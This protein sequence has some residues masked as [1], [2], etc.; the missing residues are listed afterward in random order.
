VKKLL[1]GLVAAIIVLAAALVGG[2]W[3]AEQEALRALKDRGVTWS[4]YQRQGTVRRFT[5]ASWQG[6][7]AGA[8]EVDLRDPYVLRAADI[9]ADLS[10]LKDRLS[11][12]G[13]PGEGGGAADPISQALRRVRVDISGL[14]LRWGERVIGEDLAGRYVAGQ[15]SLEGEG[16]ALQAPGPAGER[17]WISLARSLDLGPVSGPIDVEIALGEELA[18]S[19]TSP[20]LRLEHELLATSAFSVEDWALSLAGQP[21]SLSGTLDVD[22]AHLELSIACD[23]LPPTRCEVSAE[24]PDAPAKQVLNPFAPVVPELRRGTLRG[25]LGGS[26]TYVWPD[27]DWTATPRVIGLAAEG[28]APAV[29]ALKGGRFTYLAADADGERATRVTGEGTADWTPLPRIAEALGQAVMAAE[30]ITFRTHPG[31]SLVAITDALVEAAEAGELGRGGS[32]LTQQLVKNLF[33]D[34]SER[35]IARKLRELLIAVELDREL[36]KRRVLELYFNVVEWGPEIHGIKAASDYYFLKRPANLNPAECAFLAVLL[37]SPR[38]YHDLWYMR[39]RASEV[40]VGWV[41]NNMADAG[42]LSP[43]EAAKWSSSTIRFVPPPVK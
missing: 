42:W 22:G 38:T 25:E 35:T 13:A 29:E 19:L 14:D 11:S 8:V 20:A 33:L 6:V 43:Q 21:G 26:A 28:A 39:G 3:Y 41:L 9:D 4:A 23:A 40:R 32:T 24:L 10:A 5:D 16:V 27:G 37:P 34:G 18:L 2:A 12:L 17:A 30:D 31:Y 36:G 15:V 7:T 1:I